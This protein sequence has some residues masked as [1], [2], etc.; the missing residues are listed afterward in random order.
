MI[1][2]AFIMYCRILSNTLDN[3]DVAL[4]L[5]SFRCECMITYVWDY[6]ASEL[7]NYVQLTL[8]DPHALF[9][10]QASQQF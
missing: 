4:I 9:Q 3:N 2:Y 8:N 6:T 7:S 10:C 1:L 5:G